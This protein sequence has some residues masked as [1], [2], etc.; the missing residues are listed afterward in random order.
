MNRNKVIIILLI[1]GI[2]SYFLITHK[3]NA[4]NQGG[5]KEQLQSRLLKEAGGEWTV[6][7]LKNHFLKVE[8]NEAIAAYYFYDDSL[9]DKEF[10]NVYMYVLQKKFKDW[11]IIETNEAF[12]TTDSSH[13]QAARSLLETD[14][15]QFRPE[16]YADED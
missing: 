14:D 2:S 9:L 4:A 3:P 1:L 13:G 10:V 12:T 11:E 5:L 7:D 15:M 8:G 6:Y 16:Y